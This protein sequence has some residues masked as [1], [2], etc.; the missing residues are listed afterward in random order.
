MITSDTLASA[1][2][3]LLTIAVVLGI[4]MLITDWMRQRRAAREQATYLAAWQKAQDKV[5]ADHVADQ[6]RWGRLQERHVELTEQGQA[7]AR[8]V[9]ERF[10]ELHS[11]RVELAEQLLREQQ[12]SNQL[13]ERLLDSLERRGPLGG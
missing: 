4:P 9:N 5:Q 6:A 10:V 12:R 3:L 7:H 8:Q 13:L 2:L 11:R 1:F